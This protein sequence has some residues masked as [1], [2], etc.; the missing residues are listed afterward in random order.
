MVRATWMIALLVVSDTA[1]RAACTWL[2]SATDTDTDPDA[3]ANADADA[4][5]TNTTTTASIT[6]SL[7]PSDTEDADTSSILSSPCVPHTC[8]CKKATLQTLLFS[9]RFSNTDWR[10]REREGE[11]T[12]RRLVSHFS[13]LVLFTI[14]WKHCTMY[15]Q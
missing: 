10:E 8:I 7:D 12:T 13:V 14:R 6:C 5:T 11:G 2:W 9:F 15:T 4:P 1:L 3:D